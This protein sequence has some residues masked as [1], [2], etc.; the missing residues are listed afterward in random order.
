MLAV[1]WITDEQRIQENTIWGK[2]LPWL[3]SGISECFLIDI[4]AT[5][6]Y[7]TKFFNL[8]VCMHSYQKTYITATTC[9]YPASCTFYGFLHSK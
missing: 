7:V 5:Q 2:D 1:L 4:A 3:R 8:S 6:S 9:S